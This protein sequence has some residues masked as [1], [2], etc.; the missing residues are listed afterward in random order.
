MSNKKT[1]IKRIKSPD[2]IIRYIKDG[3]LHNAEGPAV[4]YPGGREEYHL[5]GFQYS[6]D[7]FKMIKKDGNGL[8]FY[9]TS[10]GKM[11]H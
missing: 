9:K 10:S 8:P 6:K 1:D 2:G 5:N 11:R 7:E 3:K 4:I